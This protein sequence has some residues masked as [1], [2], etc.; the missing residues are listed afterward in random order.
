MRVIFL[1]FFLVSFSAFA[2][3]DDEKLA[4][5]YF[6]EKQ[7]EK[8]AD[9][10]ED[11]IKKQPESIYYY[12]NLLQCYIQLKSFNEAEKL[13]DKRIKKNEDNFIYKVD[14]GYLMHLQNKET[15]KNQYFSSLLKTKY[16]KV[17]D[18]DF[19]AN[20]FIRRRF[21]NEASSSYETARKTF[22]DNNLFR[23]ELSELYFATGNT[24]A[25]TEE[26]ILIAQNDEF[27]LQDIKDK[28]TY[29]YQQK[30]EFSVLSQLLIEKLQKQPEN[31]ALNDLLIWSFVQQ[32]DWEG[33]LIQAKAIDKRLNN[34]GRNTLELA[35]MCQSNEEFKYA[36]EA[37]NQVKSFGTEKKYH[38]SAQ[39]GILQTGYLQMK[40]NSENVNLMALESEY[41][42]FINHDGNNWQ[43]AEQMY[44]LS[45]LYIYYLHQT[46][47]GIEQL[48]KALAISDLDARLRSKCK[49]NLGDAYLI[50][51]DPWEADLLYKQVEKEYANDPLGQEAKFRYA[52]LCYFRGDFPWAQT[53]LDVLKGA[54]TQ[55]ISNNALKLWLL[56]QD[57]SGLDST[58]DAL[59]LY[60]AADLL[61]FQNKLQEA[62]LDLDKISLLYPNH[63]L[64]D[65]IYF[66]KAIISEKQ[67]NY[68]DAQI[69]YESII[70]N[71]SFDILADNSLI[72]LA[73]LLEFKLKDTAQAKKIYRKIIINHSGS[74]FINEARKRY[75]FLRGDIYNKQD[76]YYY[77]SH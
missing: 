48:N 15:D 5:Q 61:I 30:K 55:L 68:K 36:I 58:D 60:A 73:Y 50:E 52:R 76:D 51:G 10:Y 41:L 29:A 72:N 9:V 6:S 3:L 26:L 33:A 35:W 53:Q 57:N 44:Q 32:K 40:L 66:A 8:A 56:I 27:A 38:Y 13:V 11:L 70:K 75:R 54:T 42:N 1:F 45:E 4:Y 25:G 43:T 12:E 20:A 77:D 23:Y 31:I 2:Q 24:N 14:K 46:K 19:L 7:Y 21:F 69:F 71:H 34:D 22:N 39:Q 62:I 65:E 59:K 37:F 16:L 63:T 74:L 49:L 64:T 18:Y 28:L 47:K 67:G 17:E